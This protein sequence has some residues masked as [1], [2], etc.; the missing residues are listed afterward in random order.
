MPFERFRE[1]LILG[2]QSCQLNS[3]VKWHCWYIWFHLWSLDH[4]E[5]KINC[6]LYAD[7][8]ILLSELEHGLPRC[9]DKLSCYAKKWQMRINVK[10]TK[11]IIF[12]KSGKIFRSEFK[13]GNQ[14]IQVID[15]YVYLGITFTPSGSFSLA[16]KK[17]Y[18]KATR[19]LYNFLSEV[20]IYNGAS[21]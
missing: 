15:S 13:L 9:L 19:S 5:C 4:V 20:N 16:Q 10:K 17:L 11:A 12:N 2:Q 21:V 8:L 7:D 1:W 14:P 18:N 3:I 6:L